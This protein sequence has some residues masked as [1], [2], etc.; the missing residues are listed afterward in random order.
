MLIR[1]S[2]LEI[3]SSFRDWVYSN[4]FYVPL[5]KNKGFGDRFG[6]DFLICYLM[7]WMTLVESL[8]LSNPNFS[9]SEVLMYT[10]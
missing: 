9:I 10:S 4:Q 5:V 6:L 1:L 7:T 3:Q 2:V 8:Y